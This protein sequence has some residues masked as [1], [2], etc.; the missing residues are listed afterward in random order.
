MKLTPD[1]IG[2][3]SGA[4]ERIVE[5][6]ELQNQ[7]LIPRDEAQAIIDTL[8]EIKVYV[9]EVFST[10]MGNERLPHKIRSPLDEI[11]RICN[12]RILEMQSHFHNGRKRSK[13]PTKE[14]P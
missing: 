8:N 10:E 7:R 2:S 1:D 4:I 12:S 11:R 6:R 5:R 9:E 13:K 14:Q 3:L